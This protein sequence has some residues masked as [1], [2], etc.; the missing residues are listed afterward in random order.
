MLTE[1][2]TSVDQ[3]HQEHLARLQAEVQALRDHL[4]R[5]QRLA[6]VGTMT[7]MVAH[8]FNNILTPII[9]Y[10]HLAR[11][12]PAMVQKAISRAE[13]GGQ[14]A[15][16]ICKAIL[17]LVRENPAPP[18]ELNLCELVNETLAAMARD[19]KKDGIELVVLVPAKLTLQAR[20]IEFQQVLLNL[21]LNARS[22]VL[23]GT[24][25][26]RIQISARRNG[27]SVLIQV[28][29]SGTGIPPENLK[30]IFEPFFTTRTADEGESHGCGL[31]LAIC[32]EIL[33]T[34]DGSISAESS[35]GQ[36]ACFTIRLPA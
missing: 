19:P 34:M 6:A 20:K 17:G 26:R 32:R 28:A 31:G 30:K 23:A 24:A 4:H 35:P 1:Q 11:S 27:Q 36:G 33:D 9:N 2:K 12:N 14:R 18:Q 10:A 22:A 5:V 29:D 25:A 3:S 15:T 7:A 16:D 21:V 13:T 8:E